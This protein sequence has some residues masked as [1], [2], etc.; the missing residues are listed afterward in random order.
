M[1]YEGLHGD[2]YKSIASL[3]K[4]YN[5]GYANLR[6][7]IVERGL[8]SKEA[9][10]N[11]LNKLNK[12]YKGLHNDYYET[13][14]E[15]AEAYNIHPA[16]L[17]SRLK[18]GMSMHEA[19]ATPVN[20]ISKEIEDHLKNKYKSL[21]DMC[22]HYNLSVRN[23]KYRIGKGWSLEEALTTPVLSMESISN[24]KKRLDNLCKQHNICRYTLRERMKKGMSFEEA[25]NYTSEVKDH[26]DNVYSSKTAMC[27][28]YN[29]PV[30]TFIQ[31][32]Q[33]GWPLEKALTTSTEEH[34]MSKRCRDHNDKEF[35]NIKEM[36]K[37]WDIG[38]GTYYS[39][40]KL[41]WSLEKIL[42][43]HDKASKPIVCYDHT[44]RRFKSLNEMCKHWEVPTSVYKRRIASGMSVEQ[45]LTTPVYRGVACTDGFGNEY[46]NIK[47]MC[48]TYN[49]HTPSFYKRVYDGVE[50]CIALIVK[51][52]AVN[53][54]FLGLD[55]K[56]RYSLNRSKEGLYTARELVVKY[57][58]DLLPAYDKHNPTEKYEPYKGGNI[59][60]N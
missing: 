49:L 33:R 58:P 4:A 1:V 10:H 18:Q 51:D 11:Q 59:D 53:F 22:E 19:L 43:T 23:F 40:L 8:S 30:E 24:E 50:P 21:V 37:Y 13:I 3:A 56:A 54:R 32:I 38:V 48:I 26:L 2:I 6:R 41:G 52:N 45:A 28:H 57:R 9:V 47:E 39:R 15:L 60:A 12:K 17:R 34:I 20:G 46:S 36:C 55:G 44:N 25:L 29:I 5:I 31:R 14:K 42:T 16:T 35:D 27:K 7:D